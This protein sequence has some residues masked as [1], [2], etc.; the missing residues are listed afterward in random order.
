MSKLL[1]G[2]VFAFLGLFAACLPARAVEITF[3]LVND[4]DQMS[5]RDGRGGYARIAA[6][7]KAERATHE[8]VVFMHAGDAISP[9][10]LSGFDQGAH[11][12]TLI[13]MTQPDVFV[14]GNH[15]F[16]FG[17]DTFRKRMS[18][19]RF[20]LLA[21]NLRDAA[22]ERLP[23]FSDIRMREFGGIK[24]GFV[25]LTTE[26]AEATSTPGDLK[27]A[28]AL[29]TGLKEAAALRSTGADV[30]VA[31]VHADRAIDRELVASRA[32]DLIFSGDDHD[33]LLNYDGRTVLMESPAQGEMIAALDLTVEADDG[34]DGRRVEWWPRFRVL[35]T[36]DFPPDPEV[37]ERVEGFQQELSKELEV[38]IGRTATELDSRRATVRTGE[39]AIGNLIADAMRETVGAQIALMNGGG[40]RAERRY[41]PGADITR[42]DILA[43]LPFG[44]RVMK[45]E[46]TGDVLRKA[47]ENGVSQIEQSA[48]RFPQV[49]GLAM[50]VNPKAEPGSRLRNVML[51]GAPLDPKQTYTLATVDFVARGG[52]GYEALVDAPRII[53]ER[54]GPLLAAAVMAHLRKRG[55]I[56]PKTEGRIE[57][58]R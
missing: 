9:S 57:M 22:G 58:L 14:P 26:Q 55:E 39:A 45:L 1:S 56:A 2:I 4:V 52:D 25:G 36:A 35:D 41:P 21:A 30:V 19:A 16:D 12:V 10:L 31:V 8:N 3:L 28:P 18:E 44:N 23:G 24:I 53:G 20:P 13:N 54:D 27:I 33:L 37:M 51:N 40:I 11:I 29:A 6:A 47:L 43:E 15:E 17:P 46:V 32:F 5:D 48:G 42:K 50:E 7:V 38:V 49:S 34:G